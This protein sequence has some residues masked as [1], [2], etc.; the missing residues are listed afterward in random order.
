MC[1]TLKSS[2]PAKCLS[3]SILWNHP[4]PSVRPSVSPSLSFV[5]IG[6]L[7]F[8]GIVHDDSWPWYLETDGAIFKKK[9]K[10]I[11]DLNLGQTG[12]N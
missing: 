8:S 5:K 4:R 6:W 9:K 3:D 1:C 11:G 2:L 12:Q 10:K 7:V